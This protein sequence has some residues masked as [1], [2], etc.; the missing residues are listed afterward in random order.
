MEYLFPYI[1]LLLRSLGVMAAL[2]FSFDAISTGQRI[3]FATGL[4]LLIGVA[5]DQVGSPSLWWLLEFFIGFTI[6]MPVAIVV[7]S[8]AHVGEFFDLGR[9]ETIG[10][11]LDPL[12]GSQTSNSA[13]LIR[14]YIWLKLLVLGILPLLVLGL[15]K[16]TILIPPGLQTGSALHGQVMGT[17]GEGMLMLLTTLLATGFDY[18]LPTAA[19]FLMVEI[20]VGF[21]SKVLPNVS[22]S[23][24]SFLVKS[25]F[26]FLVLLAVDQMEIGQSLFNLSEP[27]GSLLQ[28]VAVITRTGPA[29]AQG[30][31]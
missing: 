14:S 3:F 11:L 8:S 2:P 17:L 23:N 28:S 29:A 31:Q 19:V 13:L 20:S 25:V 9:G 15:W 26:G 21:L 1:P 5:P 12:S 16:S 24:E 30:H 6:T 18:A 22:L 7:A 4:T 10:S 27:P